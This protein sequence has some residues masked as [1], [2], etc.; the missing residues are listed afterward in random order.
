[1][2]PELRGLI[3]RVTFSTF[4]KGLAT[5]RKAPAEAQPA[6]VALATYNESLLG[7]YIEQE[8]QRRLAEERAEAGQ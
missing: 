2:T 4:D 1:M 8:V 5:G 3:Q 7:G 6:R